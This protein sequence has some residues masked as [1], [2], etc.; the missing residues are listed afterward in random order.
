MSK[1]RIERS[2]LFAASLVAAGFVSRPAEAQTGLQFF[3]VTPCR[4]VDTRSGFG[5]IMS[6]S[7]QRNFTIKGVC[8]VPGTAKAVSLNVTVVGP[9]QDG[10]VSLWPTGG[11]F[12]VVSTVN[13][14]AGEPA[15]ANG[16]I[17]PLA[18]ATPDLATIYG[19]ASGSGTIHTILD[20]TGYFQ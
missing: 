9:T 19:T 5:G 17:V 6:A 3:A 14:N 1:V 7:T 20:V 18:V 2:L 16:A 13:F 11:A 12:P 8:G 4:A 10:F 15:L